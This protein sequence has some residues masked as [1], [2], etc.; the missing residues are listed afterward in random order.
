MRQAASELGVAPSHLS[1]L[2]R[3]E[4]S[5]SDD[6]RERVAGY[7]GVESD[8]LSLEGGKLPEDVL[9]ILQSHPEVLEELRQR[10]AED[11]DPNQRGSS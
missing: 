9:Q 7:Y 6:L 8:L 2:E 10:F 3:G 5:P 11:V 1:R 4:K